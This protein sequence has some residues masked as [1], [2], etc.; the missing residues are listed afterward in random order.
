MRRAAAV[1]FAV[2]VLV[3]CGGGSSDPEV[4][5]TTVPDAEAITVVATDFAFEPATIELT[6]GEPVN[7]T[8]QVDGG[9][10]DLA[11]PDAGFRIPILDEPDAAVATLV[12]DAPGTYTFLCQVPGHEGQGMVGTITV[13]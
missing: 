5:G 9:G 3:G 7:L 10:H 11:V 4:L 8:L 13:S 12:I 6:A 1:P 2:V